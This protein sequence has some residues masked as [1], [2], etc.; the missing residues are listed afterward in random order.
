[1]LHTWESSD[2]VMTHPLSLVSRSR[3]MMESREL[4]DFVSDVRG[5][6][7]KQLF[8]V[9]ALM[10]S[11]SGP[12][13]LTLKAAK[14][15]VAIR[16]TTITMAMTY[17]LSIVFSSYFCNRVEI[18]SSRNLLS[19]CVRNMWLFASVGDIIWGILLAVKARETVQNL[20]QNTSET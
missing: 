11:V 2:I 12:L 3:L 7:V 17:S 4:S 15:H 16:L 8:L 9:G 18:G 10:T 14:K 19:S 1:M 13:F 5:G 6:K 20:G